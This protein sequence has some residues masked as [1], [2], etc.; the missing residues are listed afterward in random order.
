MGMDLDGK[1]PLNKAGEYFRANIWFWR[2]LWSYCCEISPLAAGVKYGFS[3]DGDGLDAEGAIALADAIDA[4]IKSGATKDHE[5]VRRVELVSLPDE[6]C[7]LCHGTGTRTDM[8]VANGCNKC[9]GKGKVRPFETSYPFDEDTV[10]Q[11]SKFLR[12]SGGFEIW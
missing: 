8:V 12:N 7:N 4:Q 3:N 1:K 6:A 9:L 11:F 10:R 2:P 5:N